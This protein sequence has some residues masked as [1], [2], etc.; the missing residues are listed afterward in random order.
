MGLMGN[1]QKHNR[2]F[3]L[4]VP[5][6]I[7]YLKKPMAKSLSSMPQKVFLMVICENCGKLRQIF[8]TF[9]F[10]PF[11]VVAFTVTL[12]RLAIKTT[13][14]LCFLLPCGLI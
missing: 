14:Q 3:V 9:G 10:I 2:P 5:S 8:N 7:S 1:A 6:P 4:F 11:C 12:S 13:S